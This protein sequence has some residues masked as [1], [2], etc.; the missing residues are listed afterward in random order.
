MALKK[1]EQPINED[2]VSLSVDNCHNQATVSRWQDNCQL[3][4]LDSIAE[5]IPVAMIYN[6]ISH[7]VMMASPCDLEDFATGFS[8]SEGIVQ[9]PLEIYDIDVVA[10]AEELSAGVEIRMS[11]TTQRSVQLKQRRRNLT[12]RTGCGLCGAESLE[13]AIRPIKPVPAVKL[14]KHEAVEQAVT[15]LT[16]Y[17]PLQSLTGASHGAAWCN[18]SGEIQLLREDIGRHNALDKLLGALK[19]TGTDLTDGFVLISSRASYEMVHK[20][21]SCGV[22]TLVAVS[23]PTRLALDLAKQ[24]GLNLIGFARPGRHVIYNQAETSPTDSAD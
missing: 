9:T 10:D 8:L 5:E 20:S 12:G 18:Q 17:Q 22:S 23:A 1:L 15:Q 6:G 11:I 21:S 16:Q 19:Q 24:A 7:V 14:I 4:A 2:S 3:D 13:Q